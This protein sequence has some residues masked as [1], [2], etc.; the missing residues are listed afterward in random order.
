MLTHEQL[1]EHLRLQDQLNCL[2]HPQW[3]EQQFNWNRAIMVEAAG[4]MEHI[5]WR[6][7]KP[8]EPDLYKARL[9]LVDL[10]H[11][12]LSEELDSCEGHQDEAAN[13]LM[14]AIR[15]PALYVP[16]AYGYVNLQKQDILGLIQTLVG[17][18]S[19]GYVSIT[20]FITLMDRLNLSWDELHRQYL[21]K[22]ILNIFRHQNGFQI[23][24]YAKV[25]GKHGEDYKVLT[26]LMSAEPD[27]TA[28]QLLAQLDS[29]YTEILESA[30]A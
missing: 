18:A 17:L 11:L 5:S 21:A 22:N 12:I 8:H 10:W 14:H 28:E 9:G 26:R 19:G 25:W 16:R 4:V 6:W 1:S 30:A 29:L 2:I 7:W 27:L 23:G 15:N 20:A 3:Y 24:E 13:N